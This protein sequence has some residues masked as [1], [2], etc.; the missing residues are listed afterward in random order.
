[1]YMWHTSWRNDYVC[2]T[3]DAYVLHNRH[4]LSQICGIRPVRVKSDEV[5]VTGE[6]IVEDEKWRK[7]E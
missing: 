7:E 1:M 6:N 5:R 2:D 3:G 4:S